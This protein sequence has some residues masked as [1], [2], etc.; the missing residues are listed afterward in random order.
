MPTFI[1]YLCW[2]MSLSTSDIKRLLKISWVCYAKILFA[3]V[4][5]HPFNFIIIQKSFPWRIPSHIKHTNWSSFLS[6]FNLLCVCSINHTF[7]FTPTNTK[8]TRKRTMVAIILKAKGTLWNQ[9]NTV[10]GILNVCP[11]YQHHHHINTVVIITNMFQWDVFSQ[12]KRDCLWNFERRLHYD[13][14]QGLQDQNLP[15]DVGCHHHLRWHHHICF[16][17]SPPPKINKCMI[18]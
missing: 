1:I 4:K 6:L 10:Q 2:S 3:S 17:L 7:S 5:C 14:L 18:S 15:T 8:F 9:W 16:S 11:L 12:T 13:F